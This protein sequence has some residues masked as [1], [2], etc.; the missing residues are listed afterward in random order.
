M[1]HQR[2]NAKYKTPFRRFGAAAKRFSL[3]AL[4]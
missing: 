4:N 2:I 3:L 1:A